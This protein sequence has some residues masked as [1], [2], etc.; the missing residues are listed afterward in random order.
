MITIKTKQEMETRINEL[1][2]IIPAFKRNSD[3][4]KELMNELRTLKLLRDEL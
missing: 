4:R 2:G 3:I 1:K